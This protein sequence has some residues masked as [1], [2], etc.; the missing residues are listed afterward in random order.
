MEDL[1]VCN[2]CG[3]NSLDVA[4]YYLQ[5]WAHTAISTFTLM[6]SSPTQQHT[7]DD[8]SDDVSVCVVQ[9]KAHAHFLPHYLTLARAVVARGWTLCHVITHDTLTDADMGDDVITAGGGAG[10]DVFR[11]FVGSSNLSDLATGSQ[12]RQK[13]EQA[14]GD[15]VT[16]RHQLVAATSHVFSPKNTQDHSSVEGVV[17]GVDEYVL[18]TYYD[19][20]TRIRKHYEAGNLPGVLSAVVEFLKTGLSRYILRVQKRLASPTLHPRGVHAHAVLRHILRGMTSHVAPILPDLAEYV[21][22]E[23]LGG[24]QTSI[25]HEHPRPPTDVWGVTTPPTQKPVRKKGGKNQDSAAEVD[26]SPRAQWAALEEVYKVI[27]K[28]TSSPTTTGDDVI[29]TSSVCDVTV[30]VRGECKQAKPLCE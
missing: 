15:Y 27:Q 19:V 28:L 14:R 25:F 5:P 7:P 9:D 17:E 6:T 30:R 12:I 2:K 24:L 4:H 26:T 10:G 20:I 21:Y 13:F 23:R 8:V 18:A 22:R 11:F 29:N 3:Q 1:P 16:L